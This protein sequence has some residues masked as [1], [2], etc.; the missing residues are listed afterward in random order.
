MTYPQILY[1]SILL[2]MSICRIFFSL[3]MLYFWHI[4]HPYFSLTFTVQYACHAYVFKPPRFV[5]QGLKVTYEHCQGSSLR[6]LSTDL[7]LTHMEL[8]E[9]LYPTENSGTS[10]MHGVQYT[11][12]LDLY[13]F[14]IN[15]SVS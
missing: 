4:S 2:Y 3:V 12:V 11:E 6:T 13:L 1:Y 8:L 9:C 7:S 14:K 10:T 5:G 15:C